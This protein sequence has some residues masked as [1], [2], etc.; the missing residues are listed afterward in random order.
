MKTFPTHGSEVGLHYRYLFKKHLFVE[1][2]FYLSQRGLRIENGAQIWHLQQLHTV[3]F[4]FYFNYIQIPLKIGVTAGKRF[5]F[6]FDL[7]P[8]FCFLTHA[9]VKSQIQ[10]QNSNPSAI[11]NKMNRFEFSLIYELGIAY[12]FADWITLFLTGQYYHNLTE[13]R[14]IKPEPYFSASA[15][16]L[17]VKFSGIK[18]NFGIR[19]RLQEP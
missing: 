19:F 3:H 15:D 4:E 14:I 8:Q 17:H 6:Y 5:K 2:C 12:E 7:A 16:P 18:A 9:F 13:T 11:T 10:D 1:P